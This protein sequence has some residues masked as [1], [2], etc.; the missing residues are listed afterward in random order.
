VERVVERTEVGI[1]LLRQVTGE[2]PQLLPCL[3]R[4][5]GEDDPLHLP[6]PGGHHRHGQVGLPVPA[7][8]MPNTM[9]YSRCPDVAPGRGSW[10]DGDRRATAIARGP[11]VQ[12]LLRLRRPAEELQARSTSLP[13]HRVPARVDGL[14]LPTRRTAK[15]TASAHR[16]VHHVPVG[17]PDAQPPLDGLEVLPV[18]PGD[19]EGNVVV[20]QVH[21]GGGDPGGSLAG[22]NG[23]QSCPFRRC[24]KLLKAS[25]RGAGG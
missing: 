5:T 2:K 14:Q 23:R 22:R 3:D 1:H 21:P 11:V 20:P 19:A 10:R 8:P 9:S 12:R 4:R 18:V 15:A 13:A 25:A 24:S 7:G 17:P 16:Q 6:L